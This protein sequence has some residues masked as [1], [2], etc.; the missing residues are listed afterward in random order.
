M[1]GPSHRPGIYLRRPADL[2]G[3]TEHYH[4]LYMFHLF[5]CCAYLSH[6][7]SNVICLAVSVPVLLRSNPSHDPLPKSHCVVRNEIHG[8]YGQPLTLSS[9]RVLICACVV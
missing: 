4:T 8:N 7:T 3:R 5:I 9:F 6:S 1:F 2:L